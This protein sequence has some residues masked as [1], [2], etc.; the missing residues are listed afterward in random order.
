MAKNDNGNEM[1]QVPFTLHG[2]YSAIISETVCG[3]EWFHLT[4]KKKFLI[5]V[6]NHETMVTTLPVDPMRPIY[7]QMTGD[8]CIHAQTVGTIPENSPTK[9]VLIWLDMKHAMG[10]YATMGEKEMEIGR[11]FVDDVEYLYDIKKK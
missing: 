5:S 6:N 11:L 4:K 8:K 3:T 2:C 1:V 7:W 9:S 10:T